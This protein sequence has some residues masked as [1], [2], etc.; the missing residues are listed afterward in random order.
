M[1]SHRNAN[2]NRKFK[3]LHGTMTFFP[4]VCFQFR[5]VALCDYVYNEAQ[6]LYSQNITLSDN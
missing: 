6:G 4:T 2:I 3:T 5:K 1:H